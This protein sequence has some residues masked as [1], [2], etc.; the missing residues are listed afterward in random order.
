M[1]ALRNNLKI[2]YIDRNAFLFKKYNV[3][4]KRLTN[5]SWYFENSNNHFLGINNDYKNFYKKEFILTLNDC[6]VVLKIDE[7]QHYYNSDKR[8]DIYD[9]NYKITYALENNKLSYIRLDK[10]HTKMY[11]IIDEN[12]LIS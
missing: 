5:G 4:S 11:M 7:I 9:V 3:F 10:N 2:F 12:L 8:K 1:F 6:D